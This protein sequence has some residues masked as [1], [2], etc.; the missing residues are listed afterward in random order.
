MLI[1][2]SLRHTHKW[3]LQIGWRMGGEILSWIFKGVGDLSFH[4]PSLSTILEMD[5]GIIV[6]DKYCHSNI[7][8]IK[9]I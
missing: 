4:V 1:L 2:T 5:K 9:Y 6:Q 8:Q 7:T 3:M